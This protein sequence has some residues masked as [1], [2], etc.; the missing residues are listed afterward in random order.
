MAGSTN[1]VHI[2]NISLV[3]RWASV[4]G[5]AALIG[6]SVKKGSGRTIPALLGVGFLYRGVTGYSPLYNALGM[7]PKETQASIPYRQGI[8]VNAA[9]TIQKSPQE[10]YEFWRNL[11]N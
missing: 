8:H 5:G 3:E 2:I 1:P 4:I 11:E 7:R 10:V 9:I 6:Y